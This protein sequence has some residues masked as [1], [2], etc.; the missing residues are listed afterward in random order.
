MLKMCISV[1]AITDYNELN[2]EIKVHTEESLLVL[3]GKAT[4]S[5]QYCLCRMLNDSNIIGPHSKLIGSEIAV[6]RSNDW[7]PTFCWN[8]INFLA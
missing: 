7:N 3:P 4:L 1:F 2:I 8:F 5:V 6:N